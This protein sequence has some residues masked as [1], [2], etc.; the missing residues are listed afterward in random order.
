MMPQGRLGAAI[1]TRGDGEV[2]EPKNVF[3]Q[4]QE[5]MRDARRRQVAALTGRPSVIQDAMERA[6]HQFWHHPVLGFSLEEQSGDG[7]EAYDTDG[8]KPLAL[9]AKAL[10]DL[11]IA[12]GIAA[13]ARA[14]LT[15]LKIPEGTKVIDIDLLSPEVQ[16]QLRSAK[17][18]AKAGNGAVEAFKKKLKKEIDDTQLAIRAAAGILTAQ[19]G[20]TA[21]DIRTFRN[22]L[23]KL[24]VPAIDKKTKDYLKGSDPEMLAF[25]EDRLAMA[26]RVFQRASQSTETAVRSGAI[27]IGPI[28]DD[29]R[30]A[31]K[32]LA[33]VVIDGE[34]RD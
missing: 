18:F 10:V 20:Y 26:R 7:W 21:E 11:G 17:E 3:D 14:L 25:Y 16:V 23:A 22:A 6:E 15:L 4:K 5:A 8:D 28:L 9:E 24:S 30:F 12:V 19:G 33:E 2:V 27:A 29:L 31:A 13:D 32:N 34:L 1:R